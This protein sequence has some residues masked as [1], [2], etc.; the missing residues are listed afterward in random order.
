[1]LFS[2][3]KFWSKKYY[4]DCGEESAGGQKT[5][6]APGWPGKRHETQLSTGR[7]EFAQSGPG[8]LEAKQFEGGY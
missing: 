4:Q 7:G 6:H 5:G 2:D 8:P 1:M 3:T